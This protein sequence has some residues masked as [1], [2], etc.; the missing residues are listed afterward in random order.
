MPRRPPRCP[1]CSSAKAR[2]IIYGEPEEELGRHAERGEVVLGGCVIWGNDPAWDCPEC[3]SRFG[4][5]ERPY[6]KLPERSC[7]AWLELVTTMLPKPVQTSDTG[8][9]QAGDPV[10]VIVHVDASTIAI[11]EAG[12]EVDGPP[13]PTMKGQPFATVPLRTPA[14]RV[15]EPVAMAWGKRVSRY[16]WCPRCRLVRHPEHMSEATCRECVQKRAGAGVVNCVE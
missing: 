12:I 10:V 7:E 15:A 3:G 5:R 2:P 11:M 16:R 9:L 4:D 6:M 14:A 8:E 13:T 1:D